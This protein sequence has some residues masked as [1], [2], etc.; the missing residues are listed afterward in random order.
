[1][2]SE[3]WEKTERNGG[4]GV[5]GENRAGW[6]RYGLRPVWCVGVLRSEVVR[7]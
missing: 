2:V 1:M 7:G 3:K 6:L 5:R 4:G